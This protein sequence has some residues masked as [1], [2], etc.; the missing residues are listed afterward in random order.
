MSV[1]RIAVLVAMSE[2]SLNSNTLV[3]TLHSV[4]RTR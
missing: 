1:K 2:S 3:P 4:G